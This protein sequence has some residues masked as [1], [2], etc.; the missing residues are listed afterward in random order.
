VKVLILPGLLAG[1]GSLLLA[2]CVCGAV[3]SKRPEPAERLEKLLRAWRRA[4]SGTGNGHPREAVSPEREN[5]GPRASE[6]L[7]AGPNART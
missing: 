1:L 3:F 7:D 2:G 6:V 5:R 4:P